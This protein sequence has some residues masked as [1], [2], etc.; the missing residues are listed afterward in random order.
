M[1]KRYKSGWTNISDVSMLDLFGHSVHIYST[2]PQDYLHVFRLYMYLHISR[3]EKW[4]KCLICQLTNVWPKEVVLFWSLKVGVCESGVC[5]GAARRHRG[6][7]SS[8]LSLL[9][10][11]RVLWHL[12]CW[13]NDSSSQE[14]STNVWMAQQ[15]QPEN[16]H[17]G[18]LVWCFQYNLQVLI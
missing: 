13:I 2:N 8:A 10:I 12:K 7:I 16:A 9:M 4:F 15:R 5:I 17:G 1:K 6:W 14:L 3:I 18:I 11:V